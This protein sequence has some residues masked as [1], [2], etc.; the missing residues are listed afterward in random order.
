MT[1]ARAALTSTPAAAHA[2][3]HGLATHNLVNRRAPPTSPP[4]RTERSAVVTKVRRSA[5][6]NERAALLVRLLQDR[7]GLTVSD[8]AA[9]HDVSSHLDDVADMMRIGRQ[10][11]K[12]YVTDDVIGAL[13]DRIAA[14][15]DEHRHPGRQ[16]RR[17]RRI[18]G[19]RLIDLDIE[20]RHR[21]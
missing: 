11:A 14:A 8:D 6:L 2:E 3:G 13:A 7:H 10:A 20:R 21:R 4:P 17:S 5:W 18:R 9:R 16:T 1:Y 19:Q 15:V 12:M